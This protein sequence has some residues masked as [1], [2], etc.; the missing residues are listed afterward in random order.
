MENEKL[1]IE[2]DGKEA[3]DL[4]RDLIGLEVELSDEMPT[5]FR[6]CVALAKQPDSG[7]W[8]YQDETRFRI[9][10]PVRIKI[11]FTESGLTEVVDGFIT[12]VE[13]SF[14]EDEAQSMLDITGMDASVLLDR[15]EKIRD[16]PNKMDSDI[17]REIL[18]DYRLLIP[19]I[20]DTDVVHDEAV[21]TVVQRETDYRFLK[22]LA[23]RN[24]FTFYMDGLTARFRPVPLDKQPQKLLAA[25]FGE[26]TNLICFTATVDALRSTRVRMFQVDRLT[27]EVHEAGAESPEEDTLGELDASALQPP[28][29]NGT[30]A[31]F[32]ANNAVTGRPEMDKLVKA[33]FRKGSSFV[34]GQGEID[35]AKYRHVLMPRKLVT[36]KG[37]G[38]TYSGVYYVSFVRH[39]ITPDGYT[40]FFRVTRD[41]L[42]P[43]GD[44]K[45]AENGGGL[46]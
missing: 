42:L 7:S 4:Y 22:R 32:V 12:R 8:S 31:V 39:S 35:A 26:A 33:L 2:I 41:A 23:R 34:T 11:G 43:R 37:V 30:P 17:A 27:G 10:K 24:D 14:A 25:H 20:K 46:I 36:I 13:P 18:R 44:E 38:E 21:S 16:W 9:W 45:F 29:A 15:E 6:L 28:G 40:Q 19:E 5:S 3:E 1:Y